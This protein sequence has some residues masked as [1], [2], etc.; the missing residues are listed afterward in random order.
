MKLSDLKILALLNVLALDANG[1]TVP[2]GEVTDVDNAKSQSQPFLL[3]V[4]ES[5][6]VLPDYLPD[7]THPDAISDLDK[8]VDV[9]EVLVVSGDNHYVSLTSLLKTSLQNSHGQELV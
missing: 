9:P 5:S 7:S 1:E 4:L 3:C 6:G 8:I 2:L